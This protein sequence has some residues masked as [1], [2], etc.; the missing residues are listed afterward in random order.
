[1]GMGVAQH[2]PSR[3][4]ARAQKVDAMTLGQGVTCRETSSA[5]QRRRDG[6]APPKGPHH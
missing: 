6:A 1:V 2:S 5:N 4:R 3:S